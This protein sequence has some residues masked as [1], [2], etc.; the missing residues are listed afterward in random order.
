VRTS[1][2]FNL[3]F[4]YRKPFLNVSFG[5]ISTPVISN[6]NVDISKTIGSTDGSAY[7][8]FTSATGK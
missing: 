1:T 5:D 3:R 4:S 2:P 8:G 7:I 6:L